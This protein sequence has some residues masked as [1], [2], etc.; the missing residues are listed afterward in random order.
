MVSPLEA[1]GFYIG[2]A[3]AI[4]GAI[5]DLIGAI[6]LLRF[7]NFF[8]RLHAATVA[9]IGGAAYPLIGVGLM[10]LCSNIFTPPTKYF[11]AGASISTGILTFIAAS[12]GSHVLARAAHRYGVPV[13]PK[14]CDFLETDRKQKES[15]KK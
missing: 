11:V 10:I 9:S 7:P 3:L 13:K 14:V 5:L 4:L 1:I 2:L 8:V 12:T 6:G 15:E